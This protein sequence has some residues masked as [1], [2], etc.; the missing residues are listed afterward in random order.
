M[1]EGEGVELT[2]S[3]GSSQVLDIQRLAIVTCMDARLDA[4]GFLEPGTDPVHV[5][6]NA[7]GRVSPDVLR[8]LAVAC[9]ALGVNRVLV[10]HH[11]DCAMAEKTDDEIRRTLPAN[12]SDD[13]GMEFLTI[14][15]PVRALWEDVI[16]IRDCPMLPAE[17]D[18]VGRMYDLGS[19]EYDIA[20]DVSPPPVLDD[21]APEPP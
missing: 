5:I 21:P 16:R 8:S 1:S 6:R 2:E 14:G 10:I 18:V 19:R 13:E 20:Q 3:E 11:T 12:A 9:C 4:A 17:L 15:D 7:G